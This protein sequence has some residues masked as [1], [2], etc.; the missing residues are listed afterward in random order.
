MSRMTVKPPKS[1]RAYLAEI[2]RKGGQQRSAAKT[3]AARA[4]ASKPRPNR[5]KKPL[6]M[7]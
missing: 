2:G 1:V 3:L 7:A 5:R 6:D 4:N